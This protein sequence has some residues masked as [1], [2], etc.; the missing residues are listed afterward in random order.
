MTISSTGT[1]YS[2]S[3]NGSTTAFSF[4]RQFFADADLDVYLV[5][6]ATNVATLQTLSTHY[7]VTGAGSPS[8]GTVTM[9]TAPAT[10]KTLVIHRDTAA[11]QGLDLDNVTSLPMT[12]LEAALDRAMM[13]VD[14]VRDRIARAVSSP[15]SA[16][17]TFDWTFPTPVASKVIGINS[18]AT[19]LELRSPQVWSNG[20]GV[21]SGASGSIGD[22]YMNNT[23]GD[24]YLK[25]GASTWTLQTNIRG[26]TGA[27]G[28]NG[29]NGTPGA[30]WRNGSGAP[31]A[32]LGIDGDYY[33]N[34]ANSDVYFKASGAYSVITNI[35]GA[36]GAGTGDVIGPASSVS[37]NIPTFN[38][39]TGKGIQDSGVPMASMVGALLVTSAAGT[40]TLTV[41]SPR[42]VYVTGS[43]TQ[44]IVLPD[45]TTLQLG[46]TYRVVNANSA[47]AVTVQSSGLNSFSTV[48]NPNQ[49][50][51]YICVAVTG[52]GIASWVQLFVGSTGKQGFGSIVYSG[53]PAIQQVA[54]ISSNAVTAGTNAQGQGALTETVNIITTAA[55]N[56]SGVTLPTP[57]G[58]VQARQVTIINRGANP[59]NVYPPTGGT[60]DALAA[61]AAISL[62]VG[63]VMTFWNSSLTQ[64]YSS[65]NEVQNLA[66]AAVTGTLPVAN[67]GTGV[68]TSTGSGSVVLGTGP[69]LTNPV[70]NYPTSPGV[71]AGTN[72][73]GQGALTSDLNIITTAAANPSGVT[74][75]TAVAGRVITVV[76]KGANPL[77]IFPATG[78][79]IDALAA[80]A[81]IA[82]PVG[83]MIVFDAASATQWYSSVNNITNVSLA[84]GT[85][86]IANGGTGATTQ[87]GAQSALGLKTGALTAIGVGTTAPSTP[88]T[89][90]LWVDTN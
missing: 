40:T 88:A 62:P 65:I 52:T 67:G 20:A 32:G 72:A 51:D 12:S 37:G 61:N 1:R 44:T 36:S 30:V 38:V 8:G 83:G 57:N 47:G 55:N 60:I 70:I 46:W 71:T 28:T 79:A 9:L 58:A 17:F 3:G 16:I 90:D 39:T 43:T 81:S 82:L 63:G 74:L 73:Q 53:A 27:S 87:S 56:P 19:G 41:A 11:T 86:P 68:T 5:D 49:V 54:F 42:T 66:A 78:A 13:A 29:T 84:T 10:G 35:K 89:G 64:W 50:A 48:H 24:V 59:V 14:E 6:N 4:P 33:L 18:T 77:A 31:S 23:N 22:Y 76:N 2:Y 75:P 80:N 25:T 21:P 26:T 45:V 15:L 34:T 69:T 85:L 7:T